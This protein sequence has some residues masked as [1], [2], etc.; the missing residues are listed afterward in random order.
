M[1]YITACGSDAWTLSTWPRDDPGNICQSPFRCGSWRHEGEC[2]TYK[3]HQDFSRIKEGIESR[4]HWLHVVLTYPTWISSDI[5]ALYVRGGHDWSVMRKK[6]NRRFQEFKYIQVWERTRK[7]YPHC[8]MAV[9]CKKLFKECNSDAILNWWELL[10]VPA[11]ESG[12]GK[13]G[14]C[15]PI[16]DAGSMASYLAKLEREMTGTGKSHQTPVNAPKGFRRLRA[17][18][19]VLPPVAHNPDITGFLWFCD[20]HG[21][22][23]G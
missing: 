22:V 20:L 13:I 17:S 4:G 2:R 12:F 15:K 5:K 23:R 8:H 3:N 9:S 6:C 10:R 18:R 14:W 11:I 19:G 7:G 1:D 21:E 16:R